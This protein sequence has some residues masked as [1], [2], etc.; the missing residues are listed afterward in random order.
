MPRMWKKNEI[1]RWAHK[2]YECMYKSDYSVRPSS[3][4][5][6]QTSYSNV[7]KR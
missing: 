2:V 6:A 4:H 3:T 7:G 1:D 5:A